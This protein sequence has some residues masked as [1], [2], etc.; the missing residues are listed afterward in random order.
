M[1]ELPIH[2]D[3]DQYDVCA[4]CDKGKLSV[5]SFPKSKI[6]EAKTAEALQI[7]HSDLMG[8]MK[9]HRQVDPDI[10]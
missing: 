4:G 6:N 1:K 5:K 2:D 7:I 9:Q 10:H 3:D 8:P